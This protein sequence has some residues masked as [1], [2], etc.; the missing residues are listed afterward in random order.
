MVR[1]SFEKLARINEKFGYFDIS[2]GRGSTDVYLRFGYWKQ[3]DTTMLQ[4]TIGYGIAVLEEVIEDEECG[5]L[6]SYI[7]K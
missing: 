7:L 1:I 6:Y 4:E 2:Q 3:V 5:M